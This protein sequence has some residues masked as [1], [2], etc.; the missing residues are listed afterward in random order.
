MNVK[1]C[2]LIALLLLPGFAWAQANALPQA[3]HILVY[4]EAQARAIP[5][6]FKIGIHV[7][8][9]DPNAHM[10]RTKVE[11]HVQAILAKLDDASI[12]AEEI[13]ATSLEINSQTHYDRQTQEQVFDGIEVSRDISARFSEL[14]ELEGF[15]AQLET[16][17]EVQVSGVGTYLST[18]SALNKQLRE[19]AIESTR[20]KARA[21]ASSYGVRLVGLYSV[22]DVAPE[23]DYGIQEGDWPIMYEWRQSGSAT[24]LDRIQVTGSRVNQSDMESLRTGY[25]TFEDKIYAVFLISE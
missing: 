9:T 24:H 3:P 1:T 7:Q 18:E 21:I 23:F 20:E 5:D 15:L 12:P 17:K 11:A 2:L 6:R 10:A 4:G 8:V 13:V 22:S 25:V 19:K 14:A 16:S